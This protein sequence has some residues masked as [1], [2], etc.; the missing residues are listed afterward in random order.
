MNDFW[1]FVVVSACAACFALIE[2][3]IEGPA[4]WAA[5]LPTWRLKNHW[6]NRLF[7]GR[8][9]TGYHFWTLLFVALI[10]HLPFAFRVPWNWYGEARS[11][12][13]ILFFWVIE[14]F[15]WFVFNPHY[16]IRRF[17]PQFIEWHRPSWWWL[18]PRDYWIATVIA[19]LLYMQSRHEPEMTVV[20][21]WP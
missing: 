2:I 5:N 12:A 18:A 6:L 10:A 7:P 17:R 21:R 11:C 3:Q 9:I 20:M 4:G 14:D 1:F 13:F 16:G 15:L 8:P 19:I